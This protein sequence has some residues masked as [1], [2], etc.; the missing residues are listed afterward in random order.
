MCYN[1]HTKTDLGKLKKRFLEQKAE[2]IARA[3]LDDLMSERYS[4]FEHPRLPVV[5]NTGPDR[6]QLLTW[7]LVPHWATPDRVNELMGQTLNA[8]A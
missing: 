8:R 3:E 7:G 1:V 5:T 4:G 6:I 2:E